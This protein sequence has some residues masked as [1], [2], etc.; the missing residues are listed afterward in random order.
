ME[1]EVK[2]PRNPLKNFFVITTGAFAVW[3]IF[4]DSNS[5]LHQR[6]M[7]ARHQ[8][9]IET[10]KQTLEAQQ[11][12]IERMEELKNDPN[13]LEKFAREEYYLKKPGEQ[14]FIVEE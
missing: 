14:I 13:A 3:M 9:L 12:D 8:T 6:E 7:W 1:E 10:K 11:R 2:K 4:L 5:L